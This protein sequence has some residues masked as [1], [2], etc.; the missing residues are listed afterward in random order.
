[1]GQGKGLFEISGRTSKG[2]SPSIL[3]VRARACLCEWHMQA[4][5]ALRIGKNPSPE[6]P[7]LI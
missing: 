4:Q 7:A 2:L 1:M 3:P 5:T 6:G